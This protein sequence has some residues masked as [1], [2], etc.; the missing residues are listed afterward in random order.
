MPP[1][2]GR[3]GARKKKTLPQGRTFEIRETEVEVGEGVDTRSEAGGAKPH[4]APDD[5]S[6]RA[7]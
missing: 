3:G 2:G 7:P 5:P 4:V 1:K 6:V